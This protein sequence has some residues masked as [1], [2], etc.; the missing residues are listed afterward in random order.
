MT[1]ILIK[2]NQPK[3]I[4]AVPE[5]KFT[6]SEIVIREFVDKPNE[7]VVTAYTEGFP[8]SITLWQGEQ[9]D[10]IGEWTTQNAIDRI[11]EIY[12]E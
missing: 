7:K 10:I 5:Q 6:I 4:I 3:E 8:G 11:K 2:F 12:G 9:Y 1:E